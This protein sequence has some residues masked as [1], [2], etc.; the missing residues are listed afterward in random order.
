[1]LT[2]GVP[3]PLIDRRYTIE[4]TGLKATISFFISPFTSEYDIHCVVFSDFIASFSVVSV[5]HFQ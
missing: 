2:G 3:A 5:R 4:I 1:M